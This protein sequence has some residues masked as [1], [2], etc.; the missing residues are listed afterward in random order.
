MENSRKH[1]AIETPDDPRG[2]RGIY[3]K[4][5]RGSDNGAS[6][7]HNPHSILS[8]LRDESFE[9]FDV[10]SSSLDRDCRNSSETSQKAIP[11]NHSVVRSHEKLPL[12]GVSSQREQPYVGVASTFSSGGRTWSCHYHVPNANLFL[13][14]LLHST[15]LFALIFF[16]IAWALFYNCGNPNWDA[17]GIPD[18]SLSWWFNFLGT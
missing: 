4:D 15:I 12:L 11:D 16:V 5:A 8:S 14:V 1:A 6:K 3:V 17:L 9:D 13:H 2:F 18:V 7:C 10:W